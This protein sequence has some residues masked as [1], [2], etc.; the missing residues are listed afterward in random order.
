M[1]TIKD[2]QLKALAAKRASPYQFV[3][4][5]TGRI[6]LGGAP[7]LSS[8]PRPDVQFERDVRFITGYHG[9]DFADAT[10]Y[11]VISMGRQS[12]KSAGQA[13]VLKHRGQPAQPA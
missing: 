9:S 7:N 13:F 12:G 8:I 1:P 5:H 10:A 4:T 2:R 6:R 3:G 11:C